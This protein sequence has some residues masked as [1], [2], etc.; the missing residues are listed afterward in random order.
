MNAGP[1]EVLLQGSGSTRAQQTLKPNLPDLFAGCF[2]L[3]FQRRW[4][5]ARAAAVT[6]HSP[7]TLTVLA[8]VPMGHQHV[9]PGSTEASEPSEF[10]TGGSSHGDKSASLQQQPN[11][12]SRSVFISLN[13]FVIS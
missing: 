3:M 2:P 10:G 13:I 1:A 4:E 6:S 7:H 9:L 8:R 11:K 12:T 5:L